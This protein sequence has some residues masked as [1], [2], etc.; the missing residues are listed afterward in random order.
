MKTAT[1]MLTAAFVLAGSFADA[2][3]QIP[4]GRGSTT[5]DPASSSANPAAS[6]TTTGSDMSPSR[7]GSGT[8]TSGG[9]DANG[10]Q[11]RDRMPETANRPTI[12]LDKQNKPAVGR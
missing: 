2:Q 11:G 5:G 1:I 9:S 12:P 10:D 6:P 4:N 8:S 7:S 3:S